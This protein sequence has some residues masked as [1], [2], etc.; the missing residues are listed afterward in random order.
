MNADDIKA[1]AR[2][3]MDAQQMTV[4]TTLDKA[5]FPQTRTMWCPAIDEDCT[6]YFV[7]GRSMDK[8]RQIAENPHVNVF[9]SKVEEGQLGSGYVYIKGDASVTDDQQLRYR[10]WDDMLSPFYP[11]G[12]DDPD[13]VIIMVK[14]RQLVVMDSMEV[15]P[16]KIDF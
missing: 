2:K 5:G 13:Y 6:V 14:A 15:P 1:R 11:G 4:L 9:W 3:I 10:L 7:T 16:E 12:K 8:C